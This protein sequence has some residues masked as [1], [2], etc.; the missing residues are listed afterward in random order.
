MEPLRPRL[1]GTIPRVKPKC[2]ALQLESCSPRLHRLAR[3]EAHRQASGLGRGSGRRASCC[4]STPSRPLR[5]RKIR[6]QIEA[7][8]DAGCAS[9]T[10]RARVNVLRQAL[11]F[12]EIEPNPAR[13]RSIRLPAPA[14]TDLVLPSA[15][16]V[17][18]LL[19]EL[20]HKY[21]LPLV[22][23][24]QTGMRVGEGVSL[25]RDDVDAPSLR[26][27]IK[28]TNRRGRRG[29]RSARFVPVPDWLMELVARYLPLDGLLFPDITA[30]GLR[31]AMADACARRGLTP[32]TAR[33]IN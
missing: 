17:L 8:V 28:A 32:R 9:K 24:E 14:D 15:E 21:R 2:L 16:A 26:F 27:R 11:D 10:V 20:P 18:R 12:A 13:H 3:L 25:E 22:L 7:W 4:Q 19:S 31:S 1:A 30:D 23:L 33:R 6:R 5:A 29:S